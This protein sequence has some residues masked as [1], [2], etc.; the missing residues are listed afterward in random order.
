MSVKETRN[1]IKANVWQAIAQSELKLDALSKSDLEELVNLVCDAA[2]IEF[3]QELDSTTRDNKSVE[4]HYYSEGEQDEEVVL[5]KGRPF[6]SISEYYTIT[7]QRIRIV[8]G[9]LGKDREDVELVRVQ[10]IDQEQTLRERILNLGDIIV[11]SHDDTAPIIVLNNVRDPESVNEILRR[12]VLDIR[13]KYNLTFQ[14]E[15]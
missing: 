2:L 15:M 12:A 9:I 4:A 1:R 11:R 6:L 7:N 14:E 13:K 3:D 10:D 8:R 5:W